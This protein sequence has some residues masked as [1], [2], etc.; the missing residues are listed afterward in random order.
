MT[1]DSAAQ[2]AHDVAREGPAAVAVCLGSCLSSIGFV[3]P[4]SAPHHATHEAPR[5]AG[6]DAPPARA[7][8]DA[9]PQRHMMPHNRQRTKSPMDADQHS[10]KLAD[11]AWLSVEITL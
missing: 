4:P 10:D 5:D 3:A 8:H 2:W 6:H 9:G 1:R 7:A 11:S